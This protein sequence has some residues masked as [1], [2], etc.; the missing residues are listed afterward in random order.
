MNSVIV[1]V[2]ALALVV[3]VLGVS[4]MVNLYTTT[5]H[6]LDQANAIIREQHN[7][8]EAQNTVVQAEH[9]NRRIVEHVTQI[10][11]ET[12]NANQ[13]IAPDVAVAWGDGIDRLRTPE[14]TSSSTPKHLSRPASG[15]TTDAR[16]NSGAVGRVLCETGRSLS[17]LQHAVGKCSAGS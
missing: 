15:K 14:P 12:P 6:Q 1:K 16:T 9:S 2:L 8:I 5:K 13:P 7:I 3:A 17:K 11:R 4:L 10:I